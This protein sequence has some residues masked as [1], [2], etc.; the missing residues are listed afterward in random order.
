MPKTVFVNPSKPRRRRKRNGGAAPGAGLTVR[1]A[2]Q[3]GR[4]T[5]NPAKKRKRR[6]NAGI[7]P[8]V[9]NPLILS[10]PRRRRARRKNPL[11]LPNFK[12]ALTKGVSQAGGAGIALA[13]NAF[14]LSRIQNAWMR[15]GSQFAAAVIGGAL[16]GNQSPNM[17]NAFAGAMM[18]PLMQDLASDLLGIGVAAGATAYATEADL[19]ALAADLED[20]MDEMDD[21]EDSYGDDMDEEQVW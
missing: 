13:G 12:S 2:F 7:A 20:V 17:G 4:A 11:K 8:F 19:D 10:N 5:A 3:M 18:Y 1:E 14:V 9:K 6:R 16:I 15:R 21:S